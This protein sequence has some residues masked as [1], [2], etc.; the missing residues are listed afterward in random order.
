MVEEAQGLIANKD[1][2]TQ[3][4]S[5]EAGGGGVKKG[6]GERPRRCCP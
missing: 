3:A 5:K 4:A 1:N 6:I 2:A